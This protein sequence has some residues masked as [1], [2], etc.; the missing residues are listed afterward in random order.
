MSSTLSTDTNI[1]TC[2]VFPPSTPQPQRGR[3]VGGAGPRPRD[4]TTTPSLA[5]IEYLTKKIIAE[6]LRGLPNSDT[7]PPQN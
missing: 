4:E 7:D 1:G 5:E 6:I 3:E 2:F